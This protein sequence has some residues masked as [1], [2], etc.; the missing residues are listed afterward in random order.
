MPGPR[1]AVFS[2]SKTSGPIYARAR[3]R[4]RVKKT[5]ALQSTIIG[6]APNV[7]AGDTV[8]RKSVGL[9]TGAAAAWF[10]DCDIYFSRKFPLGAGGHS[11]SQCGNVR[12]LMHHPLAFSSAKSR[13]SRIHHVNAQM[14]RK[15]SVRGRNTG[16]QLRELR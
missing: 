5:P 9:K 2:S 7:L 10:R 3:I 15:S 16:S 13:L 8:M 14:P 4:A 11:L 12:Q 6:P 1:S